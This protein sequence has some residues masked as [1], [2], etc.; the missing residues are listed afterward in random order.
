MFLVIG[1]SY[2]FWSVS[3]IFLFT[4]FVIFFAFATNS[5]AL[6]QFCYL[7]SF[8]IPL[9]E[10]CSH[11]G[12][13]Q[14]LLLPFWFCLYWRSISHSGVWYI[15]WLTSCCFLTVVLCFCCHGRLLL[16]VHALLVQLRSIWT[17]MLLIAISSAL[18]EL[19]IWKSFVC[20]MTYMF[21]PFQ[22]SWICPYDFSCV[23]H[24]I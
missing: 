11:L 17:I 10:V 15:C 12:K 21:L 19:F 23:V 13:I 14:A 8:G 9:L 3:L 24:G 18:V 6:D 20:T 7:A 5:G 22:S 16:F 2:L 1:F 4:S